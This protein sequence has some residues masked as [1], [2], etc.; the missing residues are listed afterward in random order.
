[1]SPA[2]FHHPGLSLPV[3]RRHATNALIDAI[4]WYAEFLVSRGRSGWRE[5]LY[6]SRTAYWSAVRRLRKQGILAAGYRGGAEPCLRVD[7]LAPSEQALHYP[8]RWWKEKWSGIW[9]V[10]VY[11]VPESNRLY[12]QHLRRVL[13]QNRC[14]CLQGSVWISPRDLRPLFDDL[15]T[16]ANL[17]DLAHL[18]EARTVLGLGGQRLVREAWDF[19]SLDRL[20]ERHRK[21]CAQG[22]EI[23]ARRDLASPDLVRAA[24][25]EAAAYRAV[26][27]A[28]PLLPR[29]LHPPGYDGARTVELH[30]AFVQSVRQR[31]RE[32]ERI[33]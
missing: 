18:F 19:D 10:L 1:M 20:Q 25:D 22:T 32:V 14:G 2:R 29:P 24:M 15:H 11:D 26:I 33:A 4:A 12:R 28:D 27:D 23:L 9:Y 6:G 21:V 16:A 13:R 5:N 7:H 3:L 30:R 17:G 31:A 8:E